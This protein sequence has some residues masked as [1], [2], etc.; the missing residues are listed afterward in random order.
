MHIA[1]G[2]YREVCLRPAWN[3]LFGSGG[4]AALAVAGLSPGPTLHSYIEEH[5]L[6]DLDIYRDHGIHL[7]LVSRKSV[8][9]FAYF[10]PLSTPHREPR[11]PERCHP[12]EVRGET[13]LRFGFVE[14]EAI[15]SAERAIFDPQGWLD[16]LGFYA[17]GSTADELALVLNEPEL[18]RLSGGLPTDEAARNLI[19]KRQANIV[20]IKRGIRGAT[21]L[22]EAL[23]IHNVPAFKSPRVFKIGTGDVFSALFSFYWGEQRRNPAQAA[24]D[25]SMGVAHYAA[26]KQLPAKEPARDCRA[27]GDRA[28]GPVHVI[29]AMDTIGRYYTFE[30]ALFRL[31]ELGIDARPHFDA[32]ANQEPAAILILTDGMTDELLQ[33][34]LEVHRGSPVVVLDEDQARCRVHDKDIRD[35][36]YDFTTALYHVAWAACGSK[37]A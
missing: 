10:H 31:R 30:E 9:A 3:G 35:V 14:G 19:R 8:I 12:I 33:F 36:V 21:V 34:A 1:G 26:T 22:D 18:R 32:P 17:N 2:L 37:K 29:G 27:V 28:T 20:V 11:D 15:V 16:P 13:V 24:R 23:D 5:G 4:R 6:A 7:N 25:A